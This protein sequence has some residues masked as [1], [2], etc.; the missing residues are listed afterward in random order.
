MGE[1]FKLKSDGTCPA[2]DVVSTDEHKIQCFTC[3]CHFHCVCTKCKKEDEVGTKSLVTAFNRLSTKNNFKFY[4]DACITVLEIS[5]ANSETRRL[6]IVETNV[7]SIKSELA[8]IKNLLKQS[9]PK[10]AAKP[11]SD[12][13]WF[14]KEKLAATK[15]PPTKPMLVINSAPESATESI[16]KAIVDNRISVTDSFK[17]TSGKLVM[18]CDSEDSR[19]RLKTAIESTSETV[20]MKSLTGKK[21]SVTIV[22]FNQQYSKEEI[23]NQLV[24]Q[25]QFVTCFSTLNKIDD[26][27]EIHDVKPTRAKPTVFQ[28]FASVSEA[29]RKG[30]S[31]Y[32][33]KVKIGLMNCKIYD[34]HHVK[35]CNNCQGLGHFYK[36]CTTPDE[37]YCAKCSL[38]HT[39]NSCEVTEHKCINCM[40]DGCENFHHAAFDHK[41]PS[42]LKLV[43][44]KKKKAQKTH[45]NSQ[46]SMMAH[47]H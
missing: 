22:G 7:V 43:E 31:N 34:R 14:N 1:Q 30:F 23:I 32:K 28:A 11:I 10:P 39:T 38:R 24:S 25:N 2:C 21:P 37:P 17:N 15:V 29:L 36:E 13:I 42:M 6:G 5:L 46:M 12:N 3:K 35:R 33:D 9:V 16:E 40:K 20:E 45:L 18:V 8:E 4:C 41:C 27:I 19:E 47:H 26:H 44:E